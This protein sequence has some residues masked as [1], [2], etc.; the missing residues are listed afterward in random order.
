MKPDTISRNMQKQG[1][2]QREK[3][4]KKHERLSRE[5]AER[6]KRRKEQQVEFDWRAK[7][8][9]E[10]E[11]EWSERKPAQAVTCVFLLWLAGVWHRSEGEA[12][13]VRRSGFWMTSAHEREDLGAPSRTMMESKLSTGGEN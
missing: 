1:F 10:K 8:Q 5:P 2:C 4:K 9:E 3:R 13:P 7:R 6:E 11:A 12:T